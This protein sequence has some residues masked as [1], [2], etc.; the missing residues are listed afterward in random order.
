M[1]YRL[2]KDFGKS[3]SKLN[4]K[5]LKSIIEAIEEVGGA[6]SLSDIKNCKKLTYYN[7]V[8]RIRIGARRAFFT[9]HIEII[10]DLI[11][12]HYLVS[13]GQ[14]YDKNMEEKLR[15]IDN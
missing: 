5:E 12:F 13:R 6:V 9:F 1:R 7:N 3:L 2:S 14:A 15:N 11:I 4:G 10:D 8:Y